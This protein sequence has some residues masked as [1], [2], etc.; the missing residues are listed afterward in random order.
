MRDLLFVSSGLFGSVF[1]LEANKRGEKVLANER[2]HDLKWNAYTGNIN[3]AHVQVF[4]HAQYNGQS[5]CVK[6]N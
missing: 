5:Y 6:I 3:G 2:H 1:T 4:R